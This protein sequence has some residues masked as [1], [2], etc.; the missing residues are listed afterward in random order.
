MKRIEMARFVQSKLFCV[1]K[2][3]SSS[4]LNEISLVKKECGKLSSKLIENNSRD[5]LDK[6]KAEVV[7]LKHIWAENSSSDNLEP[8]WS[9]QGFGSVSNSSI[10]MDSNFFIAGCA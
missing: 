7:Q 5:K 3:G 4:A 6:L 8:I 2:I 9:F 10:T 1:G